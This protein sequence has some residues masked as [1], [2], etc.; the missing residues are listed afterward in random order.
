[1]SRMAELAVEQD[2]RAW[3]DMATEQLSDR[4]VIWVCPYCGN[5]VGHEP[6]RPC[7]GEMGHEIEVYEDSGEPVA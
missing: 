3:Q 5:E 1:M 7:C 4:D 2:E 6:T